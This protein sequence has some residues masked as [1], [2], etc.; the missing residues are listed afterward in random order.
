[1]CSRPTGCGKTLLAQTFAKM[2]DVPLSIADASSLTDAGYVGEDV[3]NILLRL[4]RVADFDIARAERGIIY[5]ERDRQDRPQART[6]PRSPAT[7]PW[8][9]AASATQ[10]D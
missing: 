5:I 1:M 2:I 7:C 6:T 8:K 9:G 3:E 4:L 10:L